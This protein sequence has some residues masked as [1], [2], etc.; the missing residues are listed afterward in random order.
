MTV[1]PSDL[2]TEDGHSRPL[3]WFGRDNCNAAGSSHFSSEFF[4]NLVI[5]TNL[6]NADRYRSQF[7]G[8]H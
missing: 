5:A 2:P 6:E 7:L 4:N 3:Y 8:F 1:A